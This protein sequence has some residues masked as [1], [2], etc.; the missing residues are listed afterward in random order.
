MEI[1]ADEPLL[2][3]HAP[4]SRDRENLALSLSHLRLDWHWII[5]AG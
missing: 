5:G 3:S 4:L 2:D 1:G